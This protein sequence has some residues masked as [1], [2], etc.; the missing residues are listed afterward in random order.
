M[1][2]MEVDSCDRHV[3]DNYHAVEN[4]KKFKPLKRGV[5]KGNSKYGTANTA[6]I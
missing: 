4:R 1:A 6:G 3:I 2:E 5:E